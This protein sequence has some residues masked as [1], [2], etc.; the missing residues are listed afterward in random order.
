M[1]KSDNNHFYDVDDTLILWDYPT[2]YENQAIEFDCYGVTVRALPHFKHIENL[3]R[4]IARGHH[5]WVW[6]Q[7]GWEWAEEVVKKLGL[8]DIIPNE[9]I[10]CKPK[11][12]FDDLPPS[13]WTTILFLD[14]FKE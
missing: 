6:S 1:L 7:G 2:E 4:A 13:A 8:E 10:I 5:V 12:I 9:K 3:K 11:W 14:P